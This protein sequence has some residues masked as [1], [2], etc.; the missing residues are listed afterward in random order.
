MPA[1]W[2]RS[3]IWGYK[4]FGLCTLSVRSLPTCRSSKICTTRATLVSFTAFSDWR[5]H[6]RGRKASDQRWMWST[7]VL[8]HLSH[9]DQTALL[10]SSPGFSPTPVESF[11][12]LSIHQVPPKRPQE[13]SL[14]VD[15]VVPASSGIEP[16]TVDSWPSTIGQPPVDRPVEFLKK[17]ISI[18]GFKWIYGKESVRAKIL[19]QW[20]LRR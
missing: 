19:Y 7:Y 14:N 16:N 11:E 2:L 4:A 6:W 15:T 3:C 8:K 10:T 9:N 18:S 1:L 17:R 12:L 5:V 20:Q 13:E